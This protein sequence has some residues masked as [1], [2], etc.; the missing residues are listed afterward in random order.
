[1]RFNKYRNDKLF[2]ILV[3]IFKYLI[4]TALFL[5]NLVA[6]IVGVVLIAVLLLLLYYWV[7]CVTYLVANY[8]FVFLLLGYG[9]LI[10]PMDDG[11]LIIY[12]FPII[13]VT[14]YG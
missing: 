14:K 4:C 8:G 9:P 13:I 2:Y 1:M 12:I 6:F 10:I 7:I 3:R 11:T 5:F